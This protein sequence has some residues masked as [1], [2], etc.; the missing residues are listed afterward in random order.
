MRIH[1]FSIPQG[2]FPVLRL[3]LLVGVV[4]VVWCVVYGRLSCESWQ[5]PISYSR[6]AWIVLARAKS[7]ADGN[8]WPVLSKEIPTLGAPFAANWNDYPTTEDLLYLSMGVMSRWVGLFAASNLAVL[9][10]HVLAAISFY[11][12]CRL[13]KCRWEW[14]LMGALVFAFSRYAFARSLDHVM[15]AYDW[16][17]P[18]GLLVSWWLVSRYGLK[19]GSRRY[20]L[21]LGIAFA[22][23]IQ[24]PYY[25]YIFLQ[26]VGLAFLIQLVR[27]SPWRK[28]IAPV[29]AGLVAASA[30]LLMN[31]DTLT[32]QASHG[33]NPAAI[34]R[35]YSDL[36]VYALKP[37]ELFMP[38][39]NHRWKL[40]LDVGQKYVTS[41]YF[42]GEP[43]SPYLGFVGIGALALLG[44]VSLTRAVGRPARPIPVH[45]WQ[46]IWVLLYSG[47]GSVT[48][49]VG[50]FGLTMFR[51]TNRYSIVILALVLLFLVQYLSIVGRRW[52]VWTRVAIALLLS[53][54]ALWDQLPRRTP[55]I[56]Q[57]KDLGVTVA[58]DR[59]FVA[60]IEERLPACAMVFQLPVMD[61]PDGSPI[62]GV[63]TYEHF[64]PYLF[65]KH[66]HFSYGDH[67][68]RPGDAWQREV[69][70]LPPAEIVA[71]LE[72]YG[73]SAIYIDRKGYADRGAE[74]IEGLRAAGRSEMIEN[75]KGDLLCI[76]LHP[77]SQPVLPRPALFFANGWYQVE[78][79]KDGHWWR[80]SMGNA[81]VLLTNS[82]DAPAVRYLHF[83]LDT[84][85]P[86]RVSIMRGDEDLVTWRVTPGVLHDVEHVAVTLR[87]GDNFLDFVTDAPPAFPENRDPR[88]LAFALYDFRVTEPCTTAP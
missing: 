72:R 81:R 44:F 61:F 9:F 23:G 67:K 75:S 2:T 3:F 69:E 24:N 4:I 22:T 14:A 42:L 64:R 88:Q 50:L 84:L 6:D 43:G 18:L 54:I 29:T 28:L 60:A 68:G 39:K 31:I 59:V 37:V 63:D 35:P 40:W 78:R 86:R 47:V 80:W 27:K 48:G 8:F 56:R 57:I 52:R 17:V 21:A 30:F 53:L 32:Y 49:V 71:H 70:E 87:P 1:R 36:E 20:W 79:D 83:K 85:V 62:L 34:V 5:A 45:A 26:F 55:V 46:T 77:S 7:A 15:L 66:L 13:L 10:S 12:S 58:S 73:F 19:L 16:H 51:A 65:S 33:P 11:A 25:T 41:T 82:S 76:I 74:L 38:P